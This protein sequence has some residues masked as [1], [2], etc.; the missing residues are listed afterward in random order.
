MHVIH[1]EQHYLHHPRYELLGGKQVELA[2]VPARIEWI[3]EACE[4][5]KL[6]PLLEAKDFGLLPILKVHDSNYVA[7]L[8]GV[9]DEMKAVG[10]DETTFGSA[11]PVAG[12]R[13][14]RPPRKLMA[15]LGFYSSDGC[16][17]VTEGAWVA[18]YAAA[19]SA[20]T[21][22][23][24][25]LGGHDGS[26]ALCR[27]PGHHAAAAYAGGYCYLNNAAIA[28]QYAL[29]Q[30][31]TR[32]AILDVDFHHGNG[33]QSIFYNRSDVVFSSVHADPLDA[34]PYFL[35][36]A[37][38][39]G[40]G[41]GFGFN[42]NFPLPLGCALPKWLAALDQSIECLSK[43]Q[44]GLLVVSLGVDTFKDDPISQ[45][46]LDTPDYLLIGTALARLG[47]PTVFVLE[48]G[49]AVAAIGDNVTNVLTGYMKGRKSTPV[50]A[51]HGVES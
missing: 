41:E 50:S 36:H 10:L 21:A 2:D 20:L 17:P 37:D 31:V 45:F 34:Y 44:P 35:G 14:D 30:G 43:T 4:R 29:D 49:Y 8:R 40:E 47:I 11:W 27:P 32:V 19:Q 33:T 25:V 42:F 7:F 48:G 39:C 23:D 24:S 28:A 5:Q 9:W 12:M 6:G 26:I 1:S 3:K 18:A 15:R 46:C 38:E 16:S 13:H 22:V 51:T